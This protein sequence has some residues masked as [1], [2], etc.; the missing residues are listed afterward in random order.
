MRKW[1][2]K[3]ILKDKTRSVM[4]LAIILTIIINKLVN[5]I[6]T[7]EVVSENGIIYTYHFS[8]GIH[9]VV[10]VIPAGFIS[11][12]IVKFFMNTI[13][14]RTTSFEDEKEFK[15]YSIYGTICGFIIL[16][17]LI[18]NPYASQMQVTDVWEG[19]KWVAVAMIIPIVI[20]VLSAKLIN[21]VMIRITNTNGRLIKEIKAGR[22]D[23]DFP[24]L[25]EKDR[26][27]KLLEKGVVSTVKGGL[28]RLKIRDFFLIVG[29][30]FI[31]ALL[32]LFKAVPKIGGRTGATG[33]GWDYGQN[34]LHQERKRL[35]SEAN[36]KADQKRKQADYTK[37]QFIKQA[38]Y[39][40]KYAQSEWNRAVR[41]ER[42]YQK[43]KR[44]ADRL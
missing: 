12:L 20:S 10:F 1:T 5:Q 26:V 22:R 32:F 33:T 24:S 44:D 17:F 8:L 15:W 36:Y 2:M 40:P 6:M 16:Y 14:S 9:G 13:K 43:A 19:F 29:G 34:K 3:E 35:K 31:V 21:K 39:N 27:L 25:G 38:N 11:I 30:G 28:L 23:G 41:D 42:E 37:R 18:N 7:R 4:L